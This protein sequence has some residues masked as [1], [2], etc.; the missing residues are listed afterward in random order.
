MNFNKAI[1][2]IEKRMVCAGKERDKIDEL[3][4][5]LES[6]R[7]DCREA[8]DSLIDARDALSRLV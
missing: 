1:K 5:E 4:S 8:Y 6:L 7:E 3:I 2:E